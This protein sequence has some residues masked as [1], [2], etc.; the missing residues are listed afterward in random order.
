MWYNF[1]E[2]TGLFKPEKQAGDKRFSMLFPPPNITG[3]LHLGH[4]LTVAIQ[5]AIFRYNY[6][7]EPG[8]TKCLWVPGFDHAGIATQLVLNKLLTKQKNDASET[9]NQ[10]ITHEEF[11]LFATNWKED[12]VK[13]ITKQLKQ[14]GASLDFS[15][16]YYTLS[17]EMS[18]AVKEAF[19]KLHDDGIIYRAHKIVNWSYHLKSTLSDIEIDWLHL[20]VPTKIEV[21]GYPEPVEFGTMHKFAYPIANDP[22]GREIIIA[23]TRIETII[24]DLAIAVNP[25]D[26]RYRDLVG[27]EVT[28]PFTG[29]KL[30]II[31][32]ARIDKEFGTGAMKVTPSHSAIDHEIGKDHK[33]PLMNIFDENGCISCRELKAEYAFLNGLNRFAA[34]EKIR[35][36]LSK[37]GLHKEV[38]PHSTKVPLCARSGDVIEGNLLPQWF[39]KNSLLVEDVKKALGTGEIRVAPKSHLNLWLRWLSDQDWCISRQIAWGHQI[40]VYELFIDRKPTGRWIAAKSEREAIVKGAQACGVDACRATVAQDADVLDTW[41]SSALLPFSALGWPNWSAENASADSKQQ[42]QEEARQFY[43]LSLMETGHDILGFWVSR[44]ALLSKRL[45]GRFAFDEVL[46]H[47]MVCD[48]HAKKMTKSKGN[49]IDPAHV[50]EGVTIERLLQ[51]SSDYCEKGLLSEAQLEKAHHGQKKLFPQGI[52]DC[53]ADTLRLTLLKQKYLQQIVRLNVNVITKNR[54]FVNKM[55]QTYR[56]FEMNLAKG[57]PER[58][59][60]CFE[61]T[62]LEKVRAQM[63]EKDLWVLSCL[64]VMVSACEEAMKAHEFWRVHEAVHQFWKEELCDVYLESIKPILRDLSQVQDNPPP[65]ATGHEEEELSRVFNVL[66]VSMRTAL[67]CIHPLAPFVSEELYQRLNLLA[68]RKTSAGGPTSIHRDNSGKI[69][70]ILHE[71]YPSEQQ[72]SWSSWRLVQEEQQGEVAQGN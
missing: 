14:L 56:F 35:D 66:N 70:S 49:V 61:V 20:A 36:A 12:R 52:P 68:A 2:D 58:I 46:L 34:K 41:F 65:K 72:K 19:I 22:K 60:W 1:W 13:N 53:G 28:H 16:Q 26:V 8:K 48:G 44:M 27:L 3:D 40:P 54:S 6:M 62:E 29:R 32:D 57:A 64:S 30:P 23:T 43:P 33:L 21:P 50:I 11:Q 7:K 37:L 9:T 25:D 38:I 63:S 17:T 59:E 42:E 47:G 31:A 24:G 15:K 10:N 67:V 4:A 55:W 69:A 45:T 5:D 18:R 51:I 71:A 39:V